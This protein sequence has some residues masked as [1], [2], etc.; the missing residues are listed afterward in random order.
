MQIHYLQNKIN[1]KIKSK[2]KNYGKD[3]LINMKLSPELKIIASINLL[4]YFKLKGHK[5]VN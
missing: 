2:D 3:Q 1:D 4:P 5:I